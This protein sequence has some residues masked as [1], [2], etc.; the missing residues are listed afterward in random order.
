MPDLPKYCMC[1]GRDRR[2]SGRTYLG[3]EACDTCGFII[4]AQRSPDVI[5]SA[6]EARRR[7]ELRKGRKRTK[8]GLDPATGYNPSTAR[9]VRGEHYK[10]K[11]HD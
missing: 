9:H 7:A 11:A 5:R 10:A 4:D 8:G 2:P 6:A 3:Q 1:V